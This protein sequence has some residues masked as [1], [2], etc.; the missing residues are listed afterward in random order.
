MSHQENESYH[1]T[2]TIEL[3]STNI[4]LGH[5]VLQ[6]AKLIQLH[7]TAY[8]ATSPIESITWKCTKYFPFMVVQLHSI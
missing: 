1:K 3:Q 8:R 2:F 4:M 7:P 5:V 6:V